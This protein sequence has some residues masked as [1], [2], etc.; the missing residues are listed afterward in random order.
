MTYRKKLIE[1]GLPLPEINDASAYDKMPGIGAH[2]KG[3]HQWWARLPLPTARA[4]LFA[5]VVDDPSSHPDKYPTE[6]AQKTQ[7]E[8]LFHMLRNLMQKKAHDH[9]EF[10]AEAREEMLKHCEGKLPPV[11]DPFAG[12]GS[13][14][15]E[16]ARLGFKVHAAD[17]NPIAVLLNK[18][19]LELVPRWVEQSPVNP[20]SR[21]ERLPEHGWKGASGLA[22]DVRYYGGLIQERAV[23]RIGHLYPKVKLT[24]EY[25]GGE[26]SVVAWLW[27]RTIR[28]PN[29]ACRARAPLLRS[30]WLCKRKARRVHLKPTTKG[31]NLT[32]EI[33]TEGD[34]ERPTTSGKGARCLHCG[35]PI[36]K[37]EARAAAVK[38]GV[39][40]IPVALV[41]DSGKGRLYLP[42]DLL[43]LPTIDR[44][45]LPAI[46]KEM[47]NYRRWFSP[48]LYGLPRFS[49]VFTAR[50]LTA[51]TTLNELI[52]VIR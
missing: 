5:S 36:S 40:E 52:K 47:T 15:L 7:R 22:E 48:P 37:A 3:I 11:L 49:D 24:K 17:L 9:P 29:P 8:K 14:P 31:T 44:P 13:I 30:F 25:G 1:V 2:P 6:E 42:P 41:A 51:M 38:H 26:A 23:E 39:R 34:A 32:F 35:E 28:C 19:N 20:V 18:C 21:G 43:V 33:R 50:Q 16:A 46:E 12:G 45:N 27:A 10:Y 4:V